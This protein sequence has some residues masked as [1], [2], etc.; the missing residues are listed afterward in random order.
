[1]TTFLTRWPVLGPALALL[2]LTSSAHAQHE[3]GADVF[4][5]EQYFQNYCA[6]CHGA[7][8]NLIVGV[9]L[10]HGAFRQPYTDAELKNIVM[11]GITGK[12]MPATPNMSSAQADEVVKY[13]RSRAVP[14]GGELTGGNAE[15]GK[16]LFTGKG[17]CSDCHRVAGSGGRLGPDLSKIGVTR[18]A[19]HLTESLLEPNKEVQPNSRYFTVTSKQG[20]RIEG[21]LLNQDAFTVQLL[22]T[23]EQL[24]SFNKSDLQSFAFAASPMPS[25]K[26]QLNEQEL[27]DLVQYLVSLREGK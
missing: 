5:G 26:D 6:S 13:L 8:G 20:Q 16:T 2:V 25:V 7:A 3:T 14:S 15:R 17:N 4:S 23:N 24:R 1:M 11:N 10:G 27:A 18:T 12:A 9:D 22:D 21:R 19:S